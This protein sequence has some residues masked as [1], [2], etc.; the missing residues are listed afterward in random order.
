MSE[1]KGK[2]IIHGVGGAGI[3]ISADILKALE[4]SE[5]I[6]ELEFYTIDST[7][8][9]IQ[10]HP[11]LQE[12]FYKIKLEKRRNQG[13][14]GSGG[15]RKNKELVKHY[16]SNVKGYIDEFGFGSPKVNEFHL[17][18][19]SGSG[20]T[21]SVAGVLLLQELLQSGNIVVPIIIGDASNMLFITNTLNTLNSIENIARK[22]KAAI[23]AVFYNNTE[24]NVTNR[25]TEEKVNEKVIN[26]TYILAAML[27]GEIQNIDLQDMRNF[28]QPSLYKTI[29]V[30][31]GAYELAI[32]RKVLDIEDAIIARTLTAEDVEDD[33]DIKVSLLH[34]KVGNILSPEIRK[35][36][37]NDLPLYVFLRT[38]HLFE[39]VE[40][41]EEEYEKLE[42]ASKRKRKQFRSNVANIEDDDTGLVL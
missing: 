41:L 5:D 6:A 28:L 16:A 18:I 4:D 1:L 32:K 20:G 3:N 2:L 30:Q 23:P 12:T 36:F 38:N 25:A 34:N 26:M 37:E 39:I 8:K 40:E 24:N 17:V 29:Q 33:I 15:E 10:R 35:A 27:G 42:E 22:N 9:T 14:D 13:L 19:F 7:D 11:E 21:G 31:N